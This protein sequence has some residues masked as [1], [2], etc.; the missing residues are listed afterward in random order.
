MEQGSGDSHPRLERNPALDGIRA[1]AILAVVLFHARLPWAEG[2]FTGVDFFFVLSGYLITRLLLREH[3][4]SGRI[5]L[6][7]FYARRARRLLPALGVTLVA[8]LA[9]GWSIFPSAN[10]RLRLADPR[11]PPRSSRRTCSSAIAP[12]TTSTRVA[13]TSSRIPGRSR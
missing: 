9:I 6:L 3:D 11:S 7:D 12:T 2:G 8:V 4:R 13:T 1:V 10:D 5:S